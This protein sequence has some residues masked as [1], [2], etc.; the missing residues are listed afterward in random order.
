VFHLF[1]GILFFLLS[2]GFNQIEARRKVSSKYNPFLWTRTRNL[3]VASAVPSRELIQER[4]VK[5]Q[6]KSD[7]E[8]KSTAHR[9]KPVENRP[10]SYPPDPRDQK[11]YYLGMTS[12]RRVIQPVLLSGLR[13]LTR[14]TVS[15]AEQAPLS[16]PVILAANHLTNY[17]VF[18]LQA[19]IPRPIFYM[20]KE[21]LFR[22]PAMDWMLRQ[23]GGFPVYRSAGDEWALHHAE[24]V[25][26]AGQVLG[27][28]PEG[29]RSK[30]KGLKPAKTGAARLALAVGCPIVPVALHGPQYMF[31]RV[32]R[33]TLISV[34]FGEAVFPDPDDSPLGLTDRF[35]FALA[36]MLPVEQRGAYQVQPEGF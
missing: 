6:A 26:H 35:M 3:K 24:Q 7:P 33:R 34:T 27:M 10:F 12:F 19:A 9:N 11:T 21:E 5:H 29:T 28:F 23:L 31:T 18:F 30:G 1:F 36:R 17:D 13:L 15:G 4:Q 2:A 20:G 32:S 16:G 14:F 22:H 8:P 25:L